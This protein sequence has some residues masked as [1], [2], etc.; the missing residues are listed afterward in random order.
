MC[1]SAFDVLPCKRK[2]VMVGA[3]G[4]REPQC[5]IQCHWCCPIRVFS[6]IDGTHGA[7]AGSSHRQRKIAKLASSESVERRVQASTLG[8]KSA[9]AQNTMQSS[10][11]GHTSNVKG[12]SE[13]KC[14]RRGE[15]K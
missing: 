11:E 15:A 2:A 6:L 8:K 4:S 9:C 1:L 10:V 7:F 12:M 14:A 5:A 3:A 13:S